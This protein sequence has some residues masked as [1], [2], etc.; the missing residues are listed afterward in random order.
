MLCRHVDPMD[1]WNQ[2]GEGCQAGMKAPGFKYESDR[3][4]HA[5]TML[6]SV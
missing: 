5:V 3:G 6:G 4:R 1:T 2:V